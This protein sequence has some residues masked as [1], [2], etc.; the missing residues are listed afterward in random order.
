MYNVSNFKMG[1]GIP[2]SFPMIPSPFFDSFIMMEKPNF[3]YL[4]S[5]H[6]GI[7]DMRNDLVQQAMFSRCTHIIMMDT[8]QVYHPKTITR[9]L[10]HRLPVVGCLVYR[11]YPPFD[12]IMMVGSQGRYRSVP[13]WTPGD[14]VEVDA[15]GTGCL[16]F[17]MSI[18]RK[19]PFPWFR[20][21]KGTYGEMI[22]EDFGLCIDMKEAG[23]KIFVDTSIPA[24]HLTKMEVNE[25]TWKLFS[26]VKEAELKREHDLK[27]G[28]LT[29]K[30]SKEGVPCL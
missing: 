14:L 27:H 30:I 2:L 25:G 8:D 7:D 23:Y 12:P 22:G 15:T 11:R 1:I 5:S 18:F 28:I 16:L 20:F 9:L 19:L 13:E 6:A 24:G 4:R 26:K 21:R 17:E 10:S 29:N 3:T